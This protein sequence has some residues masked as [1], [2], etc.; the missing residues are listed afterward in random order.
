VKQ[1]LLSILEEKEKNAQEKQEFNKN[2]SEVS[3][4][5]RGLLK[6]HLSLITISSFQ[7]CGTIKVLET[8]AG[9]LEKQLD[10]MKNKE[11]AYVDQKTKFQELEQKYLQCVQQWNANQ[12]SCF[13]NTPP[14]SQHTD[15]LCYQ[16]PPLHH[17]E[18]TYKSFP[19]GVP[20]PG[21][22]YNCWQT[23]Q[24]NDFYD[25]TRGN[26]FPADPVLNPQQP[27]NPVINQNL[28]VNV[29]QQLP[30]RPMVNPILPVNPMINQNLPV[31]VNPQL[32]TRPMVNPILPVSPVV[33]PNLPHSN[34]N[35]VTCAPNPPYSTRPAFQAG[36]TFTTSHLGLQNS[37]SCQ[38]PSQPNLSYSTPN[39]SASLT[40]HYSK[41]RHTGTY[42]TV[43]YYLH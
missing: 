36:S 30:T 7:Q 19:S 15:P 14:S 12:V 25:P 13:G 29:N 2:I 20:P 6:F 21:S 26:S 28:P 3:L 33:N 34:T 38:A 10:E 16:I 5:R 35:T 23:G 37:M 18:G 39:M 31:N 4:L 32:P 9:I 8:K 17:N 24:R 1:E 42:L 11:S 40:T 43:K 41:V 22:G 27:V